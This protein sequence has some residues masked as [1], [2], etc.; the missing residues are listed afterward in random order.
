MAGSLAHE[1]GTPLNAISGHLRLLVRNHP[2]DADTERRVKIIN[3]QLDSVVKAVRS[4]LARTQ[5]PKL[6]FEPQDL[7]E[8]VEE[9][10]WLVQPTLELHK[11]EATTSLDQS[12]PRISVDRESLLQL[13][14]NLTNNSIDAMPHGGKIEVVT[15]MNLQ[16][17]QAELFFTD[18]GEGIPTAAVNHLF[19]PLWTTKSAGS[20]FGLAI[21]RAVAHGHGGK[22]ELIRGYDHGARFCLSLP[23]PTVSVAEEVVSSVA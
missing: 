1:I 19:E 5:P 8:L 11:I 13:L 16:S 7:N 9:L 20:G 2:G 6:K 21:A 22:I 12:L 15:R 10:L 18:T 14:L 3:M 17:N 23:L 4:L